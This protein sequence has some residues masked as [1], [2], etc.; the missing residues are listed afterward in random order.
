MG[1]PVSFL[2]LFAC[3]IRKEL[4][5]LARNMH[6]LLVLFVMP[7]IFV[8]IMSLALQDQM[9]GRS[10]IVLAGGYKVDKQSE[11]SDRFVAALSAQGTLR[12]SERQIPELVEENFHL[13]IK[14]GFVEAVE[15][16]F[17]GDA[18]VEL[19]FS[20]R[21]AARERFLVLAVVKEAFATLNAEVMAGEL[22]F[23]EDYVSAAMIKPDAIAIKSGEALPTITATQQNV[24]AW[25][26]FAM[27]FISLPIATVVLYEQQQRTLLRLRSFGI[28][29]HQWLLAKLFPYLLVNLLQLILLLTVGKFVLPLLGAE[30]LSLDVSWPAL[31]VISLSV[32]VAAIGFAS[33]VACVCKSMDQ[34]TVVA[35]TSNILFGAIGGIMVPKFVMPSFLQ[36]MVYF[37][38]MGW[39]L[40]GFIGV[41]ALAQGC[42]E[43]AF[44]AV[45]LTL[46]GLTSLLVANIILKRRVLY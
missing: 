8:L 24:P 13:S 25:L 3:S 7:L 22:G 11:L 2:T 26:V 40:E 45:V 36:D 35:G 21:M 20:P 39:G 10:T 12:L 41:L 38:P 9:D 6:A 14:P 46:F 44:E 28:T 37:S 29:T 1:R 15:E 23:D 19:E 17:E 16:E 30:P 42:S 18:V 34:A 43:I 27:F 33:L 5:L 31:L 4:R 32:S